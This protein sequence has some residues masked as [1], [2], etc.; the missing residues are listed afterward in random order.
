MGNVSN[1]AKGK[2]DEVAGRL[3]GA[4]G[5]AI[6]NE[7]MQ[8]EGKAREL[9]GTATQNVAKASERTKGQVEQVAGSAKKGLGKAIGNEQMQAEGA[10]KKAKGATR[11]RA[12]K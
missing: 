12:N 2:V 5:K 9:K 10:I 3:K 7:Q 11:E 6:G 8:V 4:V 1:R